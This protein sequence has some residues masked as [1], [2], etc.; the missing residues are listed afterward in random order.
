[1]GKS[2]LLGEVI[3]QA[4]A[5]NFSV[6]SAEADE[7]GML[8]PFAPLLGALKEPL[9]GATG[10]A[11]L[12]GLAGEAAR[13]GT[14]DIRMW[15]IDQ[16]RM[17]LE[18]RAAETPVLVSLD[19]LQWADPA[20]LLALRLLPG[21]LGSYPLVWNLARCTSQQ[22]GG[23]GVL[24]DLLGSDG[25]ARLTLAPLADQA[26]KALMADLLGA[27]PDPGL[28]ALASGAAGN[29]FLLVELL[30]GLRDEDAIQVSAGR[31][32]RRP[33]PGPDRAGRERPGPR[34]G[35]ERA[36]RLR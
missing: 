5:L 32:D 6:I 17:A 13:S 29:P 14:P 36:G 24:F 16:I 8:M 30:R 15:A 22:R 4:A 31:G 33:A 25:A 7:L 11:G 20:T 2:E 10:L 3:G 34:R 28:T 23:A 9:A 27:V 19:D 18:R 35:R 1:M 12:P 21:Q 26:V